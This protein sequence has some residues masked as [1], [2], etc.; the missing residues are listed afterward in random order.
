MSSGFMGPGGFG[1]DPFGEFLARF[2]G[3]TAGGTGAPRSGPRQVDIGR[4]MSEPARQ[5]VA[6]AARY[7]AE[8]GSTDLDTEHLRRAARPFR[9]DRPRRR[10]DG[11][12]S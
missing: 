11:A 6:T 5:L 2:F 12:S 8:H 7:A 3:G 9:S 4:L 1:P 10:V